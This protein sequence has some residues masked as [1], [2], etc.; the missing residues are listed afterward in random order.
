[1]VP[2]MEVIVSLGAVLGTLAIGAMSPGPSFVLVARTSIGSSRKDGLA[3]AAGMGLGGTLFSVFG[4]FGV[5]AIL[6]SAPKTSLALR[7]AGASYLLW[8]AFQMW[9]HANAPVQESYRVVVR[10]SARSAFV[11]GLVTQLSNPKAVVVYGSIFAALLPAELPWWASLS[12]PVLVFLIEAGW[13]SL[14]AVA[15]SSAGPRQVYVRC[16]P[17]IDRTAGLVMAGLGAKLLWSVTAV[18]QVVEN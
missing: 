17:L 9:R 18:T 12:L 8:L 2:A 6:A 16:K 5:H 11:R 3:T 10:T 1:M 4:L 15:L 13:Y 14:V 7:I